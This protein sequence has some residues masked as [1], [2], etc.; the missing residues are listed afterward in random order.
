MSVEV[1]EEAEHYRI[2]WDSDLQAVVH[3]WTDFCTG[4]DFKDGSNALLEFIRSKDASKMIVDTS[5]IQAHDEED[6]RWLQE[7]WVPKVADAGVDHSVVVHPDSVIS[8]MEMEDFAQE[9]DGIGLTQYNTSD[10]EE[11]RRWLADK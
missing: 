2:E 8:Q 7:V 11:A 1:Y 5:G 3:F 10:M 9:L 4:Q 6:K